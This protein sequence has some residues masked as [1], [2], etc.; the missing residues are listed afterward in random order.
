M[1]A[2][3]EAYLTVIYK[4]FSTD[5]NYHRQLTWRS[6]NGDHDGSRL[7]ADGD[8]AWL[9]SCE[10]INQVWHGRGVGLVIQDELTLD[11]KASHT[12]GSKNTE[13]YRDAEQTKPYTTQS[14]SSKLKWYVQRL[15]WSPV[16][17]SY[18]KCLQTPFRLLYLVRSS[19]FRA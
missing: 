17:R 19:L 4:G 18:D 16:G 3:D 14:T 8:G 11:D 2:A 7:V 5:I 6:V 12:R 13:L 15:D 9:Q 1:V 10:T